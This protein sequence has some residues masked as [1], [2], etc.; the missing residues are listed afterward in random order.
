MKKEITITTNTE[1]LGRLRYFNNCLKNYLKK[2]HLKIVNQ[3]K[4]NETFDN[5]N[6]L[7][8]NISLI[9]NLL[10]KE[11][12]DYED[13]LIEEQNDYHRF[14]KVGRKLYLTH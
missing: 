2:H 10:K 6:N 9:T 12:D 14:N 8:F 5:L 13:F 11:I 7:N 3:T 4:D 1:A